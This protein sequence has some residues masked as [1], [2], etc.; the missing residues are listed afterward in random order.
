MGILTE[1][2]AAGHA[3][4]LHSVMQKALA[5][6]DKAV[7]AFCREN[8]VPLFDAAVQDSYGSYTGDLAVR[9]QFDPAEPSLGEMQ[10][11]SRSS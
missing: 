2:M 8:V 7:I 11:P 5:T 6:G 4:E 9:R 10:G 3:T 1:G